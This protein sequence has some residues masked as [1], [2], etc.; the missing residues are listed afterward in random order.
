M[1]RSEIVPFLQKLG[2]L[3]RAGKLTIIGSDDSDQYLAEVDESEGNYAVSILLRVLSPEER[4]T[5]RPLE[6]S[7]GKI[8][9]PIP[10]LIAQGVL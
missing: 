3:I 6:R 9:S 7:L 10:G 2:Y 1:K 8:L 5:L 4:E